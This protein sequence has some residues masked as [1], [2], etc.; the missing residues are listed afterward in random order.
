M[1]WLFIPFG[2]SMSMTK[3]RSVWTRCLFLPQNEEEFSYDFSWSHIILLQGLSKEWGTEIQSFAHTKSKSPTSHDPAVA[4]QKR[5]KE[6]FYWADRA[7]SH[8]EVI[9]SFL[10]PHHPAYGHV[11]TPRE[12]INVINV[13]WLYFKKY[14]SVL[15][16]RTPTPDPRLLPQS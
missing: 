7:L 3:Q 2:Q 6:G 15:T 16:A 4:L 1:S 14:I 12:E 8:S 11:F 5:S 13:F 10:W 9:L